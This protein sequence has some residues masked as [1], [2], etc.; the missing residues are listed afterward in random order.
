MHKKKLLWTSLQISA[1]YWNGKIASTLLPYLFLRPF[2]VRAPWALRER[3]REWPTP[4]KSAFF[5]YSGQKPSYGCGWHKK[6]SALLFQLTAWR[7]LNE[8]ARGSRAHSIVEGELNK[9]TSVKQKSLWFWLIARVEPPNNRIGRP[10]YKN[11]STLILKRF[12]LIFGI[13]CCIIYRFGFRT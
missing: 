13:A 11:L 2:S 10:R 8:R 7:V 1:L 4:S 12:F 6:I 5:G 3:A 9:F